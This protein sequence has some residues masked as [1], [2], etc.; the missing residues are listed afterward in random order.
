MSKIFSAEDFAHCISPHQVAFLKFIERHPEGL[1]RSYF[2]HLERP[3]GTA[4]V[5]RFLSHDVPIQ[6]WPLFLSSAQVKTMAELSVRLFAL[7]RDLPNCCFDGDAARLCDFYQLAPEVT[8][9][10]AQAL[11]RPWGCDGEVMR[12]D[13]IL[14]GDALRCIEIN[15]MAYLGGAHSFQIVDKYFETSL[16]QN[17]FRENRATVRYQDPWR[18]WLWVILDRARSRGLIKSELNG[19]FNLAIVDPFAPEEMQPVIPVIEPAFQALLLELTE[20]V[21][22]SIFFCTPGQLQRVG[23]AVKLGRHPIH[24]VLQ[25]AGDILTAPL[26]VEIAAWLD[27]IIDLYPG[28]MAWIYRDKRNLALLSERAEAGGFSP[29]D[30]ALIDRHVPWTRWAKPGLTTYQREKVDLEGLLRSRKHDFVLKPLQAQSGACVYIGR[31]MSEEAWR[32]VVD[33]ALG[34]GLYIAQAYTPPRLHPHQRG[35]SGCMPC[36]INWGLF[37]F[38]D[39]YGGNYLRIGPASQDG[40]INISHGAEDGCF[41]EFIPGGVNPE[42]QDCTVLSRSFA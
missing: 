39:R 27:G 16:Y 29:E 31:F 42:P 37:V 22:G 12:G 3:P 5:Q 30:T 10:L 7:V 21:R 26:S 32:E 35:D 17:F 41:F 1:K 40:I 18:T 36:E 24:A 14:S 28:P 15:C 8:P 23:G 11:A 34:D 9:Y 25:Y 6:P 13:F 20:G 19:E 4:K 38:G 2:T 33:S